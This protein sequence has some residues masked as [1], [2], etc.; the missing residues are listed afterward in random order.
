MFVHALAVVHAPLRGLEGW[1]CD[2]DEV[3][4]AGQYQSV[5]S[6]LG[7]FLLY[8]MQRERNRLFTLL[9]DTCKSFFNANAIRNGAVTSICSSGVL[10]VSAQP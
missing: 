10:R 4:A 3:Q 2:A 6:L 7:W 8:T 9:P 5:T 1:P